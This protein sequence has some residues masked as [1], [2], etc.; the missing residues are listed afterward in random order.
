MMT[1]MDAEVVELAR[2]AGTTVVTLMATDAWQRTRDGLVSLWS[3]VHPD[4]TAA[5]SGELEESQRELLAAREAGDE[6]AERELSAEWQ[7]RLRRLLASDPQIADELRRLLDEVHPAL[8]GD[9]GAPISTIH[10][11]ATA[12]GH[13]R[14]YQAGRD[15]HIT[16]R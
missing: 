3:R 15:Q 13:G 11:K 4:R 16:E 2:T 10:Q 6:D 1:D 7:A 14:V 9:E 5:V 12:S 8:P